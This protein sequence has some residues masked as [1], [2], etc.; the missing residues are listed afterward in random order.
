[1]ER[2]RVV[3]GRRLVGRVRVPG[4]KNS[5]LKLMAAAL[6]AEGETRIGNL[7]RILDVEIMAELLRRMGCGVELDW[8][9]EPG[10]HTGVARIDVPA[11]PGHEA[12]YDLVRR[13]RASIAVLGP[14]LARCGR[15]KVARPGGDAIGSRG[16]D[17]HIDGLTRLGA[18]ITNEHGF[19]LA[20]APT[21]LRGSTV[22]LDF[23]SVGATE[24]ILMAAVL[25]EG[26]T[27][28]DNAAREPEIVDLC[29]MLQ[30][31]GAKI[32][33]AGSSTIEVQGVDRL[34]PVSY[35]TLS[36]RIVAGT[37]AV[38]AV[39]TQ[40]DV[41]V[42]HAVAEH[43]R[44]ALDK[45]VAAGAGITVEE[46]GFRVVMDRR[47]SAVDVVTLPYP[48][49]ATDLQPQFAALNSVADGVSMITE[50][51]FEAR[52]VFLQELA[53][54]GAQVRT[55][56]H[57]AV[58]RGV[59]RLS[60]APVRSTDIRAGAGLLLAGLVAEG[61]T[62]VSEIHHI[63]RGYA[64]FVEQLTELGADVSREPDPDPF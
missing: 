54:L 22:E 1:M 32:G 61:P 43:L 39:M 48:G 36:D 25:A 31:M 47:P 50:N 41:T 26:S 4:A 15:V 28:I 17:M 5:A 44:I 18:E 45:L 2:L 19:L 27:V 62:L 55:D 33:G 35:E 24:N 53:R 59:P 14:L 10:D 52:F 20:S 40:G 16:L 37:F 8:S 64:G 38:A 21:G 12:D 11:E 34:S 56:G 58:L 6:L 46:N 3:G 60:G 30:A 42:G 23:P 29:Q 51:I 57:H 13:M 7:P 49:F 9:I 63:D